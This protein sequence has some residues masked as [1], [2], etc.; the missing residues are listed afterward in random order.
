M[1]NPIALKNRMNASK[2]NC[3]YHYLASNISFS[4]G[5]VV[6]LSRNSS[7]AAGSFWCATKVAILFLAATINRPTQNLSQAICI[8]VN[9]SHNKAVKFIRYAHRTQHSVLRRLPQR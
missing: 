5:G 7:V 2:V 8:K 4:L 6:G 1:L 9:T 3:S